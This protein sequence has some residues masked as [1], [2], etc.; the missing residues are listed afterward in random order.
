MFEV[1][2]KSDFGS[3]HNLRGH[4]GKC[5]ALHGHN[6]KVSVTAYSEVLDDLGMVI[7]FKKLKDMLEK[8]I[9]EMDHKYLNEIKP[10]D[11]INPTSENIAKHIF[12]LMKK[13]GKNIF[14]KEVVVWETDSSCAKYNE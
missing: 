11:S 7:D 9:S 5:E 10:F 4:K 12:D 2:V 6:W 1:T 8:I 13:Q 14:L 3:A